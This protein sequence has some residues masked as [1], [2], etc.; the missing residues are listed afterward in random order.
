MSIQTTIDDDDDD[1]VIAIIALCDVQIIIMKL[2]FLILDFILN[3]MMSNEYA[4]RH[5]YGFQNVHS[6]FNYSN[7]SIK[8][9]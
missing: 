6:N 5:D 4:Q 1:A 7:K 8:R 3:K 9:L 2:N